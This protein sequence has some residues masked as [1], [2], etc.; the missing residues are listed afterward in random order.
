M[1]ILILGDSYAQ[2]RSH[3]WLP[4]KYDSR[5]WHKLL[6]KDNKVVNLAEGGSGLDWSINIL[7]RMGKK[8]GQYHKI[9]L[10]ASDPRRS[11][12]HPDFHSIVGYP[13][14]NYQWNE[15]EN[16]N[17]TKSRKHA[18]DSL[19]NYA[20]YFLV[21]EHHQYHEYLM[22]KDLKERFQDKILILQCFNYLSV[23]SIFP[24]N[25][26]KDNEISLFEITNVEK[27]ILPELDDIY[28]NNHLLSVH[29]QLLYKKIYQW[30]I[31]GK[32]SL[33]T[34]DVITDYDIQSLDEYI[35]YKNHT[36]K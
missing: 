10:C 16:P 34:N 11:Y 26:Y 23:N 31:T 33:N 2:P 1:K 22:Y 19:Q 18:N 32:F 17:I 36:K 29:H 3:E 12:L 13:H 5:S 24:V 4:K 30:L 6:A 21:D 25:K 14:F 20:K 9:I 15:N 27:Q 28:K 7:N 8:L 35:F